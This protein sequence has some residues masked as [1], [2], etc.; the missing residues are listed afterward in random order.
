M[1]KMVVKVIAKNEQ[2]ELILNQNEDGT[3]SNTMPSVAF[4]EYY[5]DIYAWDK[6]GNLGFKSKA[7]FIVDTS[8]IHIELFIKGYCCFIKKGDVL[9]KCLNKIKFDLGEVRTIELEVRSCKEEEFVIRSANIEILRFDDVV[10]SITPAI[11]EHEIKFTLDTSS[12]EKALYKIKCTYVVGDDTL[13][14]IYN[15]EV[16]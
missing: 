6:A 8:G 14:K 10:M 1:N 7:L 5:V 4:G 11:D 3:W 16:V 9:M 12:L 15:L 13:I 2:F